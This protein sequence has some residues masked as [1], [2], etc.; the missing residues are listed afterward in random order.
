MTLDADA[1]EADRRGA[2]RRRRARPGQDPVADESRGFDGRPTRGQP[3]GVQAHRAVDLAVALEERDLV[4]AVLDQV[5]PDL[6]DPGLGVAL[7]R[8]AGD[9]GALRPVSVSAPEASS[10]RQRQVDL[11]EGSLLPKDEEGSREFVM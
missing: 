1:A 6:A 3:A 4:D 5:A 8:E 9:R 2:R 11:G 7:R 10:K